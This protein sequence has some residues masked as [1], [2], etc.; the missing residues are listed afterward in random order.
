MGWVVNATPWPLYPREREPVR[1][2]QEDL[3]T[4]GPVWTGAE[5]LAPTAQGGEVEPLSVQPSLLYPS[6]QINK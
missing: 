1:I 3:W 5:N 2:V 4:S 6:R